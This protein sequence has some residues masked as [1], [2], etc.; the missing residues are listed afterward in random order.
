MLGRTNGETL[1]DVA[2]AKDYSNTSQW[3]LV[4]PEMRL[5]AAILYS[6]DN[7]DKTLARCIER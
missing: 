7:F 2:A 5:E 3:T 6:Y 4:E 1:V